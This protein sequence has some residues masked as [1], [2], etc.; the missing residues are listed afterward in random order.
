MT[1]TPVYFIGPIR[2]KGAGVAVPGRH[3]EYRHIDKPPTRPGSQQLCFHFLLRK[4]SVVINLLQKT[5]VR[6]DVEIK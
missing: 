5:C 6:V 4:K 2:D 1:R 3:V